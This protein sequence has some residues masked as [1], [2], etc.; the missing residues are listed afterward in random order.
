MALVHPH[1]TAVVRVR[2]LR[3]YYAGGVNPPSIGVFA[4]QG[5]V[6]EHLVALSRVGAARSRSAGASE[7]ERSTRWSCPAASRRR[8]PSWPAPSRCSRPFADRIK[9]GMPTFGTCAGMI[10]LADR[11]RDGIAGPGDVRRAR[12]HGAAQRVRPAGGLVRIRRRLRPIF[13]RPG[14]R[15]VHPR[16]VGRGGRARAS[17]C[18]PPSA[19]PGVGDRIVAVQQGPVMATS[20]HPEVSDDLRLHRYFLDLVT[21]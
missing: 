3:P 9:T 5:D 21:G 7:L 11:L 16:A 10:M 6:R 14:A 20:F 17:T 2:P 8:W 1:A 19:V 13:E 4:L 12:H 18:S 15:R